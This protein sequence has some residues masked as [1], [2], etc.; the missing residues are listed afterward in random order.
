MDFPTQRFAVST[1]L[2]L[3]VDVQTGSWKPYKYTQEHNAQASSS[4]EA[5]HKLDKSH[6]GRPESAAGREVRGLFTVSVSRTWLV[7]QRMEY[8]QGS[9]AC[10]SK[11][12]APYSPVSAVHRFRGLRTVFAGL[13]GCSQPSY[14]K[15]PCRS[16]RAQV[17]TAS[18]D[19][20]MVTTDGT[21]VTDFFPVHDNSAG[22]A[23]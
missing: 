12:Q 7:W 15:K 19:L 8:T 18:G 2:L 1:V 11:C 5:L 9:T 17:S 16:G 21:M 22:S 3:V 10:E 20:A 13:A 23:L 14:P 6:D 4:Q